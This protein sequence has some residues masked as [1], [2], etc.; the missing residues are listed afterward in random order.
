VA[1]SAAALAIAIS[2]TADFEILMSEEIVAVEGGEFGF[3]S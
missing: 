2:C 1:S 3:F